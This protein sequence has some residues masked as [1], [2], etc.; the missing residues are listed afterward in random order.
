MKKN[1]AV[2]IIIM[3]TAS[4]MLIGIGG[5]KPIAPVEEVPAVVEEVPEVVEAAPEEPVTLRFVNWASAEDATRATLNEIIGIFQQ[6][7]PH[8]TIENVPIP[9]GEISQQV[10]IM[11]AGDNPADIVQQS[12]WM[13]FELAGMDE[14]ED[15]YNYA[16]ESYLNDVWPSA[17]E[18]GKYNDKLIAVPWSITPFG[19]WYNKELMT[20]AGISAPPKNWDELQQHLDIIKTEY[21]GQGVDAL[22]IFTA[23]PKF[24]VVHGLTWFWAFGANPLEDGKANID[25]PEFK[26]ALSWYRKMVNEGYTTGGWK[27]R[28]FREAFATGKLVYA[29]DGPYIRGIMGS[30]NEDI[31]D[32]TINDLYGVAEFPFG[33]KEYTVMDL[34]QLAMSNKCENKEAAWAFI[35]F[36]TS[37]DIAIEKYILPMGAILPLQSQ[38]TVDYASEFADDINRAF[39]EDVLPKT[40]GPQYNPEWSQAAD[41]I[42]TLGIQKA[43][44]TD[45]SI[46]EIASELEA[47]INKIYG[48]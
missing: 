7:N 21:S 2:A 5:C 29:F 6:K 8:I 25:T 1:I 42:A 30:I 39:V 10:V 14:V 28:E 15:L 26:E 3:F 31:T 45:E 36:L 33:E 9:F 38:V 40:R 27:L 35:E 18:A 46:D 13:P 19:F 23:A 34:H 47:E 41:I 43:C 12:S 11:A 20:G 44:F 24:G 22:E 37:S 32:E 17:L 16:P 48:W 4:V